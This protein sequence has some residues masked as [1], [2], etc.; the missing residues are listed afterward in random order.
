MGDH[1]GRHFDRILTFQETRQRSGVSESGTTDRHVL[2]FEV[3]LLP[4]QILLLSL[5]KQAPATDGPDGGMNH[6]IV[7]ADGVVGPISEHRRPDGSPG[8]FGPLFVGQSSGSRV[9]PQTCRRRPLAA[10]LVVTV[11]RSNQL[12]VCQPAKPRQPHA[13][14]IGRDFDPVNLKEALQDPTDGLQVS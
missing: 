8:D 9:L 3:L 14:P 6:P 2:A 13:K 4:D 5:A 10:V 7:E 12:F 1:A 11:D